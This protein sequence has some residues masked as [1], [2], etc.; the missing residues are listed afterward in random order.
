MFFVL[1]WHPDVLFTLS[2][3]EPLTSSKETLL[4]K[5]NYIAI[6]VPQSFLFSVFSKTLSS[7]FVVTH[8]SPHIQ[9][10]LFTVKI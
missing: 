7:F 4:L 8:F 1:G 9:N 2:V 3:S 5:K 6:A 10:M